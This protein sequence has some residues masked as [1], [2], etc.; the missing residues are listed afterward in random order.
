MRYRRQRLD[1]SIHGWI[2]N[3]ARRN[4]WR[5]ASWYELKD[6]IQDG[7]MCYAR[8][9]DFYP[10]VKSQKH[11]MSLFK[12]TYTNYIHN[13]AKQRS[14]QLDTP[15]S[16]LI[17][18]EVEPTVALTLLAG[19]Q[20]EEVTF[21]VLFNQLP[22]EL[23]VLIEVYANEARS[24]PMRREGRQRETMNEYLCRLGGINPIEYKI[25]AMLIAHF[26]GEPITVHNG[27]SFWL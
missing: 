20:Q 1:G 9:L 6:L 21:K 15:I 5:V 8:C 18:R 16:E 24:I 19:A 11:F 7:Y 13:L 2:K 12:R 22:T 10:Q 4:F 17:S 14:R 3:T 26:K 27:L 23:K 25:R